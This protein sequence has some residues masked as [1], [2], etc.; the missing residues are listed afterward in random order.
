MK[1][2]SSHLQLLL[3]EARE[4]EGKMNEFKAGLKEQVASILTSPPPSP[5]ELFPDLIDLDKTA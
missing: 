3:T 5:A 4:M 1:E 2:L